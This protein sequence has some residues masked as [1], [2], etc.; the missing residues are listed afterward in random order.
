MTS[1]IDLKDPFLAHEA[2]HTASL[3]EDIWDDHIREHPFVQGN[4][5]LLALAKS[6]SHLLGD[7]YQAVGIKAEF[8]ETQD[9]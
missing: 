9:A 1:E 4:P 7:F 5:D 2:L 3:V 8:E 6:I